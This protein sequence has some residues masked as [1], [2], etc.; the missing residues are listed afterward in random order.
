MDKEIILIGGAPTVGKTYL[1][2]KIG[3]DL[4]LP[5]ISTDT[6]REQMRRTIIQKNDFPHLFNFD[7]RELP[8]M[9]AYLNNHTPE[10]IIADT[11]L[12]NIEVWNGVTEF[13]N[14]GSFGNSYIIEGM[15]VLPQQVSKLMEQEKGIKPVFLT[16]HN[17]DRLRDVIYTRGL[18]DA[19][20]KYP[21]SVKEKELQWVVL[22]NTW[23]K[24]ECDKYKIPTVEI[25]IDSND[26]IEKVK[27]LI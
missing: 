4:K 2:K 9:I 1:A 21:D 3:K 10:Q 14:E 15:A 24:K 12:E 13:I 17:I 27:N 5:W 25:T 16:D 11:N 7:K 20:F 6:I 18:W 22:F 23:I 26:Y 19:A 8:N